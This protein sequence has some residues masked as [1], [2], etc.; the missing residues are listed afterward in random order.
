MPKNRL[1]SINPELILI[2]GTHTQ[3]EQKQRKEIVKESKFKIK[4]YL[5]MYKTF[6]ALN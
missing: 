6:H 3:Q 2:K 4:T 5:V 1:T